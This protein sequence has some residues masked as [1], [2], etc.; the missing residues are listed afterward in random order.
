MNSST[1]YN[2]IQVYIPSKSLLISNNGTACYSNNPPLLNKSYIIVDRYLD[3][4]R[5]KKRNFNTVE[6]KRIII[7]AEADDNKTF[8]I[9]HAFTEE[10]DLLVSINTELASQIKDNE[11]RIADL[12]K[13]I[14]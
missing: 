8:N 7:K 12:V 10:I 1:D 3:E 14:F 2:S 11:R 13:Q 5:E 9:T 4:C 6:F